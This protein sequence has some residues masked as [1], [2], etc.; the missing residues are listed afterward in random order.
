MRAIGLMS[1]TSADAVD[2]A[3]IE[4]DGHT[5]EAFGPTLSIPYPPDLRAAI[6]A[7]AADPDRAE[8]DPLHALEAEITAAHAEA[9]RALIAQTGPVDIIGFHGQTILHRPERR[10]TRQLGDGP[11]LAHALQTPVIN[12]FRHADIAAGGQGAPLVPI[13]HQ[14]LLAHHPGPIAILNLGG[15]ANIT[16]VDAPGVA[17][18]TLI[19]FDTG[20][21]S[22]LLDDWVTRHTGAP[23]DHDGALAAAGRV[24]ETALAALLAHP[25]F[26]RPPPK[27]LDRNAFSTAHVDTLSLPDGAATLAAFTAQAV[28]L[29][30]QHLPAPPRHWF[31]A[32]GGRHNRTLMR[33]LAESLRVPVDPVERLGWDGD[34]LEAQAFAFLAIRSR[35]GLPLTFPATTGAPAPLQGGE[36]SSP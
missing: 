3:L 28:G 1:G 30:R 33:L 8:H 6:L 2:A 24:D 5:I 19:A 17:S 15:V 20:P 36:L 11:T 31:V 27:S 25:Y 32:G 16:Y 13:F 12:R 14:A 21:A 4:A 34:A 7:V 23:F 29:A 26:D 35:A 22:A 18:P 10:L 9:A